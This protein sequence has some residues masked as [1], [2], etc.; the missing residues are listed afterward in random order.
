MAF[1]RLV[2]QPFNVLWRTA[3]VRLPRAVPPQ[4]LHL[5]VPDGP[6]P[7]ITELPSR[8]THRIPVYI[9]IPRDLG[10]SSREQNGQHELPVVLDFHGGGFFLGSC[11]E[12]APFCAKIATEI[13]GV[14]IT[15]DYRMGPVDKFPAA[16]EDAEDV[17]AAIL[18]PS[19]AGYALLRDAIRGKV[20][21]N[22]HDVLRE[23]NPQQ[24][25]PAPDVLAKDFPSIH[26]AHDRIAIS[27]FSSGGNLA[28]NLG[29]SV[30]HPLPDSHW[31]SLFPKEHPHAIPLLLFYPSLDARQLPSER[32]RPPGLP[33]DSPFWS[34]LSD[35]LMPTYL[36]R[37]LA[38]H[39][40]AS[41]GLASVRDGLHAMARVLL[42]LPEKDSLAKQSEEWVE[43]VGEEGRAEHLRVERVREMAHGWTQMPDGW[44]SG[45][46]K[47]EKVRMFNLAVEFTRKVWDGD[48]RVL[49][50]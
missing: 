4:I 42:V 5:T 24:P 1:Q 8:G 9:F 3:L 32:P 21:Q 6:Y 7:V 50:A 48:E 2:S 12:Q 30:T 49:K 46:A 33:A 40:R 29:L 41:P 23:E 10:L 38:G 20:I 11:L 14:A 37:E 25:P 44:L 26:L 27:G 31:P 18:D 45:Q 34:G 15:V 43:R 19:V 13:R 28:L 17:L 16:L 36:P 47:E 22:L 39:P 35:L